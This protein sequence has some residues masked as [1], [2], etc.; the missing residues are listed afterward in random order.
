MRNNPINKDK[1]SNRI[2]RFKKFL[3]EYHALKKSLKKG[4]IIKEDLTMKKPGNG[5]SHENEKC[6]RKKIKKRF[7]SIFIET[8]RF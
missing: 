4:H 2:N 6:F 8:K 1:V 3:Q 7:P 5:I